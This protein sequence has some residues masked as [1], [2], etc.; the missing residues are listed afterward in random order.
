ML[1]LLE[2]QVGFDDASIGFPSVDTCM[3]VV[4][5]TET[6]LFGWH[7]LNT[8]RDAMEKNAGDLL[9]FVRSQPTSVPVR[10]Y[11]AMNREQHGQAGGGWRAELEAIAEGLH[12]H[13]PATGIDLKVNEG[14]YV[15]F[16]RNAG[17]RTCQ[18]S[19]KRNSKMDY[20]TF[21]TRLHASSIRHRQL[22]GADGFKEVYTSAAGDGKTKVYT[23]VQTNATSANGQLNSVSSSQSNSITIA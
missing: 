8:S 19:Y 20:E 7:S 18:V 4:L 21:A 15:Q 1:Q 16:E 11:V 5:Q 22:G 17:S 10:L 6:G 12:Y 23:K 9:M 2:R 13:G 14:T 3:A